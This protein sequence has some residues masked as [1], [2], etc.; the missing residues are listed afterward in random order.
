M[1]ALRLPAL[2]LA[3]ALAA[4]DAG[5][6][7][8]LEAN[9]FTI[10]VGVAESQTRRGAYFGTYVSAATGHE[11]FG[12]LLGTD[13]VASALALSAPAVGLVRDGGAPT[14]GPHALAGVNPE[15]APPADA[16][17]GFYLDPA[18]YVRGETPPRSGFYF[19]GAGSVRFDD[20][21]ADRV[22]GAFEMEAVEFTAAGPSGSAPVGEAVTVSGTFSAV[23]S[24][25]FGAEGALLARRPSWLRWLPFAG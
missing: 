12:I 10:R 21:A 23:P 22:R 24:E 18:E 11:T 25:G 2:A 8:A 15:G 16:F 17:V 14:V 9:T 6:A 13:P 19:T 7:P 20:L 4:C 3:L 5:P 1:T